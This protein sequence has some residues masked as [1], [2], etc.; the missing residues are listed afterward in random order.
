MISLKDYYK[1]KLLF[2]KNQRG[3]T[4]YHCT[5]NDTTRYVQVLRDHNIAFRLIELSG[6]WPGQAL[7][8]DG[9]TVQELVLICRL[10]RSG[11]TDVADKIMRNLI[12]PAYHKG[13]TIS[14]FS[15]YADG[16][17]NPD[18][19]TAD[20]IHTDMAD[21]QRKL[22]AEQFFII[23]H[24]ANFRCNADEKQDYGDITLKYQPEDEL[25]KKT[26]EKIP[27][28][29]QCVNDND[30]FKDIEYNDGG[31]RTAIEF[32][33][34]FNP[35]DSVENVNSKAPNN[36]IHVNAFRSSQIK[37]NQLRRWEN[38]LTD[39]P[40]MSLDSL[41][42]A[43]VQ[44]I[45]GPIRVMAPAGAGKTRVLIN[46]I[47][48]LISLGV[49]PDGILALAFN[50][51][52]AEEMRSRLTAQNIPVADSLQD[53]GVVVRTFH[54]L[55]YEMMQRFD[56]WSFNPDEHK[57]LMRSLLEEA[58]KKHL[59]LAKLRNRDALKPFEDMLVRFKTELPD[60][61][62]MHDN[63]ETSA[64]PAI[65]DTMLES[66]IRH[67]C[68][69]YDDMLYMT[70]RYLITDPEFRREMQSRFEF[71]M[72]DEFQ[73]LNQAQLWLMKLLSAPQDNLFVVGDDD[74]MIYGWRGAEVKHILE[75]G[76]HYSTAATCILECNY[77]SHQAVIRHS[78]RLIEHNRKRVFKDI[79]PRQDAP[80]GLFD[81]HLSDSLLSQAKKAG[82][83]IRS[84]HDGN[85]CR[86]SEF[87]VL[88]RYHVYQTPVALILD[89]LNIPHSPVNHSYLFRSHPGRDLYSYLSV[90]LNPEKASREDLQRILKRPNK[91]ITNLTIHRAVDWP[92]LLSLRNVPSD[93]INHNRNKNLIP[94]IESLLSFQ[95]EVKQQ[96]LSPC[97]FLTGLDRKYRLS[98][99][100]REYGQP[101]NEREQ[102]G[103]DIIWNVILSVSQTFSDL[104]SFYGFIGD[105]LYAETAPTAAGS[106][107]DQVQL[108]TIHRTKGNEYRFV[109]CYNVSDRVTENE[110]QIEEERRVCYVAATRGI[111]SVL[112]TA[113]EEHYAVFVPELALNPDLKKF[114]DRYIYRSVR[115][116][117]NKLKKSADYKPITALKKFMRPVNY[118]N[119]LDSVNKFILKQRSI[120]LPDPA[121]K[122][123]GL[124][125]NHLY[126]LRDYLTEIKFRKMFKKRKKR[127]MF[128]LFKKK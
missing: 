77:R 100:Y 65:F 108:T 18:P 12:Y 14:F 53:S 50:K 88:Y 20:M 35:A 104:T 80:E 57:V 79:K 38:V 27:V 92:S 28:S 7:S 119:L 120:T 71:I 67:Q 19:F 58:V 41:Q 91:Y 73:D 81:A 34:R 21:L 107:T 112:V 29:Q 36:T 45:S 11:F 122:G 49:N 4:C 23:M 60:Y 62:D 95:E 24:A 110:E 113:P 78:R 22:Y 32:Y 84:I 121:A 42:T 99:F 87:A 10:S 76:E 115:R 5:E 111:E 31:K 128:D 1:Y 105:A 56:G 3:L 51:K 83:W 114:R 98:A 72:V 106:N 55:G 90:L 118:M 30:R 37:I 85:H 47:I 17:Y 66:Q 54:S 126:E 93:D 102:A 26:G 9:E 13:I 94:F 69:N 116:C 86:W 117:L 70:L 2:L 40:V 64:Y 52:A 74:Q 101:V 127:K 89:Q 6:D 33:S 61:M 97:M 123:S 109:I 124:P 59:T 46:R 25:L 39:K 8:D 43:A 44:H 82:E 63:P 125:L 75:F 103:D 16:E 68:M 48:Y 96:G 15:S